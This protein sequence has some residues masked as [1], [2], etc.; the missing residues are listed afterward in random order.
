MA[1]R[2]SKMTSRPSNYW[3]LAA[4]YDKLACDSQDPMLW[5]ELLGMAE[6]YRDIAQ[7]AG[8]SA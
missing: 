8:R 2:V 6:K 1:R 4:I 7:G 3:A 5:D